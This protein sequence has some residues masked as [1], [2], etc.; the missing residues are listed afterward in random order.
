MMYLTGLCPTDCERNRGMQWRP[1]GA[2][3]TWPQCGARRRRT[4]QPDRTGIPLPWEFPRAVWDPLLSETPRTDGI[5]VDQ[6]RVKSIFSRPE[7]TAWRSQD[8]VFKER[9]RQTGSVSCCQEVNVIGWNGPGEMVLFLPRVKMAVLWIRTAQRNKGL[10]GGQPSALPRGFPVQGAGLTHSPSCLLQPKSSKL[11]WV[12]PT[13]RPMDGVIVGRG[14]SF[15]PSAFC[16]GPRASAGWA[17]DWAAV[18]PRRQGR[19]GRWGPGPQP[20]SLPCHGNG[21]FI[22][23]LWWKLSAGS[24]MLMSMNH[25]LFNLCGPRPQHNKEA[26]CQI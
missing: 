22:G 16:Q 17:L 19:R 11:P 14:G 5:H 10:S 13:D 20:S 6:W 26:L 8:N 2:A 12:T 25:F 3:L 15:L 23:F 4:F 1:W 7:G 21:Q 18:W 24:W 9:G